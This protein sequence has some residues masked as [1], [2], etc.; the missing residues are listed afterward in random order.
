M[1]SEKKGL[2]IEQKDVRNQIRRKGHDERMNDIRRSR[3]MLMQSLGAHIIHG[4]GTIL[5]LLILVFGTFTKEPPRFVYL[6]ED[7]RV[8]EVPTL[9][10]AFVPERRLVSWAV[11]TVEDT[12]SL[13]PLRYNASFMRVK[14]S[15]TKKGF[16]ELHALL[17]RTVLKVVKDQQVLSSASRIGKAPIIEASGVMQ[18]RH[19]WVVVFGMNVTYQGS[20]GAIGNES[21]VVK[22][23]VQRADPREKDRALEIMRVNLKPA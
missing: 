15:Y 22:V 10:E 19:V 1:S 14:S 4:V 5:L 8:M 2:D 18:G 16:Q 6:T 9:K 23:L 17:E 21:F 13:D 3:S 12:F 11:E 7:F 20:S